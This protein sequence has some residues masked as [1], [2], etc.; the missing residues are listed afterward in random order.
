MIN[1]QKM[2]SLKNLENDT[3][4]Y[5]K[6]KPIKNLMHNNLIPLKDGKRTGFY[7][8]NPDVFIQNSII[9]NCTTKIF[10]TTLE[11]DDKIISNKGVIYS[12]HDKSLKLKSRKSFHNDLKE[13]SSIENIILDSVFADNKQPWHHV[14]LN[15]LK[16]LNSS[17]AIGGTVGF[18]LSVVLLLFLF[19]FLCVCC[20]RRK[21]CCCQD[22]KAELE[23]SVQS[24]ATP[25][26]HQTVEN[27]TANERA[28][29]LVTSFLKSVERKST[30]G[31]VQDEYPCSSE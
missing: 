16:L 4:I 20:H 5:S 13:V 12:H 30:R 21:L 17:Q 28:R 2:V 27:E 14:V 3:L 23:I 11:A 26:V 29:R 6:T 18:S 15:K 19:V 1:D 25:S 8:F 22:K 31:K 10:W 7:C 9:F 24:Q